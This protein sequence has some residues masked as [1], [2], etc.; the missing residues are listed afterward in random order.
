MG[1]KAINLELCLQGADGDR[2]DREARQLRSELQETGLGVVALKTGEAPQ[3]A[4][5][6][7]GFVLGS[8]VIEMLPSAIS[9]L[10]EHLRSWL[11]RR[12]GR[13]IKVKTA[14]GDRSVETE[15]DPATI[16]PAEVKSLVVSILR[17]LERLEK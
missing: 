2:L 17:E 11:G 3:G 6:I 7:E 4:K 16:T 9:P 15:F 10:I 13:I 8:L 5:S 12:A 1:T 14:L